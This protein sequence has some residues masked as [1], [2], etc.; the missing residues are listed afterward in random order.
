MP[1]MIEKTYPFSK[2]LRYLVPTKVRATKIVGNLS[3]L[4]LREFL[5]LF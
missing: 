1:Q 4:L 5:K 3:K 2:E